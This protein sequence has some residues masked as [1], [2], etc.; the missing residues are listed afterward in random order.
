MSVNRQALVAGAACTLGCIASS[1]GSFLYHYWTSPSFIFLHHFHE[2]NKI[3]V[4]GSRLQEVQLI[5]IGTET[6]SSFWAYSP[7]C[8]Q[9]V[10][11]FY[12]LLNAQEIR[13][14]VAA[15]GTKLVLDFFF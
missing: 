1:C 11:V 3:E 12:N 5:N 14:R 10:A 4:Y 9:Q 13:D 6:V 8:A 2:K 15:L 7:L